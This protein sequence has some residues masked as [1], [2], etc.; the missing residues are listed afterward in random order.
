[1]DIKLKKIPVNRKSL[2]CSQIQLPLRIAYT[3]TVQ[4]S[5]GLNFIKKYSQK[6]SRE[7]VTWNSYIGFNRV[8]LLEDILPRVPFIKTEYLDEIMKMVVVF[9]RLA[10]EYYL[11]ELTSNY[12]WKFNSCYC[13]LRFMLLNI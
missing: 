13:K 9:D 2:L 6:W 8:S 11:R 7:V 4:K 5:L 12:A 10:F 3:V 1:M